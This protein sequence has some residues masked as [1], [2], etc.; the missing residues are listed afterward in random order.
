MRGRD[1]APLHILCLIPAVVLLLDIDKRQ[2][3]E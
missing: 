3:Y 2:I 1:R